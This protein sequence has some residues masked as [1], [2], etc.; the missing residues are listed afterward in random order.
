MN[1]RKATKNYAFIDGNNLYLGAKSQDIELDYGK[2]RKYLRSKLNVDRAFLFIGYDVHNTPLYNYLQ[3]HG[4]ILIFKPTIPYTD[5]TTGERTMKG[6]VDAELVL[7]SSAI[8]FSNYD[9]AIIVSSDGDFACLL[10]Y[11]MDNNK[12]AKVITPTLKYSK[13]LKPYNE[14]IVPLKV[15]KSQI[16]NNR[17]L[18]S[19]REP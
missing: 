16:Q 19:V 18:R 5:K 15:I 11:L 6:N 7:Y 13:L 12:L 14:L 1:T 8:E 3:S 10:R 17:D 2:F 4:Y 9:K